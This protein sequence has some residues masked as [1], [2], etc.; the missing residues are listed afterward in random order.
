[1]HLHDAGGSYR[2]ERMSKVNGTDGEMTLKQ[3]CG[4]L[5][6]GHLV[7]KQLKRLMVL[8]VKHCPKDHHDW[9]EVLELTTPSDIKP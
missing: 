8:A 6:E 7:N 4:K 3:W 5:Y 9:K 1:M 2:N